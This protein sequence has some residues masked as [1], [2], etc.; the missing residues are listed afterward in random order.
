MNKLDRFISYFSPRAGA[1]RAKYRAVQ[2]I[3]STRAYDGAR[4]DRRTDNWLTTQTSAVAEAR[5]GLQRL[6]DR[7][8]DLERNDPFAQR[9]VTVIPANV[10]GHGIIPQAKTTS[11]PQKKKYADAWNRWA[12]STYCDWDG[13]NNFYGLQNLIMRSIARDGEC[14][15]RFRPAKYDQP[16]MVPLQLQILEADFLDV[17]LDGTKHKTRQASSTE[18]F[19]V[20]GVLFDD[21]G[22]RVGYMVYEFHPGGGPFNWVGMY[23]KSN[24]LASSEVLHLMRTDRAGQVRGIPWLAPVIMKLKDHGDFSEASLMRQKIAACFTAFVKDTENMNVLPTSANTIPPIGETMEPGMI[25][26]LRPGQDVTLAQPPPS[27]GFSEFS[28]DQLRAI[29]AG[30]GISYEALTGDFSQVNFSSGRMGRLEMGRNI[31]SW[32]FNLVIPR[33]CIPVWERWSAAAAI[34]GIVREPVPATWTPPR[35]EYV[36]PTKEIP[37]LISE[38][39]AGF[40]TLPE[41]IRETG[42]DPDA[43]ID[44]IAETNK[45]LDEAGVMLDTDPRKVTKTGNPVP[46]DGAQDDLEDGGDGG[47]NAGAENQSEKGGE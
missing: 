45:K 6:R 3:L 4:D 31:D 35:R 13:L 37:A 34:A 33:F 24:F 10:I 7:S 44:E 18:Y 46:A 1:E 30:L 9:A 19:D 40:K 14:L 8:R 12:E 27:I 20:Q 11:K 22:K 29:A 47:G 42:N 15:V 5:Q 38:V 2:R 21:E 36:D 26:I 39:R 32:Q 43:T 17:R 28:R 23:Y 16:G 41:A 25:E